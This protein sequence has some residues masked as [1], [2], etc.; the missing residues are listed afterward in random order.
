MNERGE[1]GGPDVS[2]GR[3][4]N[5]KAA[6]HSRQHWDQ[7]VGEKAEKT[8]IPNRRTGI[9]RRVILGYRHADESSK[10]ERGDTQTWTER[11]TVTYGKKPT[12]RL[13]IRSPGF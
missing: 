7:Q 6:D 9:S 4:E 1:E 10:R 8:W 13:G 3:W 11:R 5:R 2:L 12:S